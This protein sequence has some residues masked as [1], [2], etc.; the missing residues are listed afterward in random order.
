MV[1]R[2]MELVNAARKVVDPAPARRT[3]PCGRRP[4]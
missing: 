2:V 4:R 3:P 1:A